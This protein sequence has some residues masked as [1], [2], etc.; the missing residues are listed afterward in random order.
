M[1]ELAE[2]AAGFS[3]LFLTARYIC[4]AKPNIKQEN[5]NK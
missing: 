4:Q 1:N 2:E 5:S 3:A